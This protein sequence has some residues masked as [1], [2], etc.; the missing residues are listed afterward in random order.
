LHVERGDIVL[1]DDPLVVIDEASMCD[2]ATIYR[3]LRRFPPGVRMLFVGDPGQLAPI[4][5]GTV[6][7][8]LA[9]GT[10]VP[11][12]T[13]TKVQRQTSA[14]GIP[15]V[16]AAIRSGV[17]P[18]FAPND[19]SLAEG[20]GFIDVTPHEVTEAVM[21]VLTRL[22]G[23]SA[24]QVVGS[25][26]PRLGG[27]DEINRRLHALHGAGRGQLNGRFYA[28]EPV[29]ATH[30]DYDL[31]VMNGEL[32]IA[33]RNADDGGGLVCR[34]DSGDKEVPQPYLDDHLELA[35]AITCHKAQG[36]QFP[37]V[38]IPVTSSRLLDRSLL[39]TAVSRAQH[40]V[41]LVGDR[42]VFERAIAE[43]SKSDQRLVGLGRSAS[44]NP[45]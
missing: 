27:V 45:A 42:D 13:L 12:T 3:L 20:V 26:K 5:F 17:M 11:R 31:A 44:D 2:L 18:A 38:V 25:V 29:I 10:L 33:L 15:A 40:R 23:T 4:G 7:H 28:G 36:S 16:C 32:G 8:V 1:D 21:D 9:A 43:P 14:S 41:V 22:G 6:F 37:K 39:L 24:V 30:N 19:W 35:Y 34:F